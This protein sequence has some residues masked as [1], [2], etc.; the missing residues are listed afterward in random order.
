MRT[1]PGVPDQ[2]SPPNQMIWGPR[3]GSSNGFTSSPD[4]G[5]FVGIT[6]G[7]QAG[8]LSQIINGLTAG[9][10]YIL[11]FDYAVGELQPSQGPTYG[12]WQVD[13]GGE[14]CIQP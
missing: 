13:L 11:F 9:E 10:D 12:L 8:S 6:V 4:G 5:N 14:T 2:A 7:S 3:S 1:P